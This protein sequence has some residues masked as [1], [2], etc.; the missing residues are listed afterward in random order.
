MY[1]DC[2]MYALLMCIWLFLCAVPILPLLNHDSIFNNNVFTAHQKIYHSAISLLLAAT[3]SLR[4]LTWMQTDREESSILILK[5]TFCGMC[6]NP[7][8]KGWWSQLIKSKNN[9][10][11][12]AFYGSIKKW[13]C[14]SR[15]LF[16]FLWWTFIV[17]FLV[18]FMKDELQPNNY[19]RK[20]YMMLRRTKTSSISMQQLSGNHKSTA[21]D[22]AIEHV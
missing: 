10:M 11:Q 14:L 19:L 15:S 5:H 22:L 16:L 13:L 1:I 6:P 18:K 8:S 4:R 20:Y 7:K 9:C 2:C 17:D 21:K 12:I 3:S